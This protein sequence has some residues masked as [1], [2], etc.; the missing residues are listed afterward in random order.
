MLQTLAKTY[1]AVAAYAV[2]FGVVDG[3]MVT[4][5]T[6]ASLDSAEESKK[7][8]IFGLSFMCAGVG[9]LSSPPLSGRW[10]FYVRSSKK[11]QRKAFKR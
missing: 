6:I 8:S 3:L 5:F 9:A 1:G 7:A 2:V 4:T 11:L 10:F